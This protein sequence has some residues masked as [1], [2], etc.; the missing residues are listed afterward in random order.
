MG[1]G[2]ER[3]AQRLELRRRGLAGP[4]RERL[5]QEPIGQPRVPRQQRPVEVRPDHTP[6]PAAFEAAIAV[7]SE[8]GNDAAQRLGA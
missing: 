3:I 7:V 1:L 6:N 8:A 4:M 2:L 5:R